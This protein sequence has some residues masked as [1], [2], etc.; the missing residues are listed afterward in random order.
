MGS[1]PTI[2]KLNSKGMNLVDECALCRGG[3]ESIP[4]HGLLPV[5]QKGP[6]IFFASLQETLGR[7]CY[8]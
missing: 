3:G 4:S 5:V 6:G 7:A 1:I 8:S 2:D